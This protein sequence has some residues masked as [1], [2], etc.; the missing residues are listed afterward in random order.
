MSNGSSDEAGP[1]DGPGFR[2]SPSRHA[3]YWFQELKPLGG[4]KAL[5]PLSSVVMTL[6]YIQRGFEGTVPSLG[7]FSIFSPVRKS[8]M[9]LTTVA[10]R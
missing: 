2:V 8:M 7:C 6:S 10:E 5:R 9:V 4:N 1:E 3:M